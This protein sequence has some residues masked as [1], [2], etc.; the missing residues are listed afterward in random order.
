MEFNVECE[1]CKSEF[2]MN[3]NM[4]ENQDNKIQDEIK[5]SIGTDKLLCE[6]CR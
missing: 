2:R 3:S 4:L 5:K 6:K 1:N